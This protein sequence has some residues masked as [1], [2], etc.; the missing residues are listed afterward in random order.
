MFCRGSLAF[1]LLLDLLPAV[2]YLSL[3]FSS[4]SYWDEGPAIGW[5]SCFDSTPWQGSRPH[6]CL[7][8]V[9]L[10]HPPTQQSQQPRQY[11]FSCESISGSVSRSADVFPRA[12]MMDS[13]RDLQCEWLMARRHLWSRWRMDSSSV[14]YHAVCQC[15]YKCLM[16]STHSPLSGTDWVAPEC[17]LWITR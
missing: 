12:A 17:L 11:W 4:H 16:E 1:F 7:T 6:I 9:R 15:Q 2:C 10:F 14:I 3:S 13:C 5:R 8:A